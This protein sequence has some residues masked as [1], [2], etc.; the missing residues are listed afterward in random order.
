MQVKLPRLAFELLTPSAI[1]FVYF[2]VRHWNKIDD[3][4]CLHYNFSRTVNVLIGF[5]PI[6]SVAGREQR[7]VTNKRVLRA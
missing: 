7:T 1:S 2:K 5:S 4:R 3:L 6:M